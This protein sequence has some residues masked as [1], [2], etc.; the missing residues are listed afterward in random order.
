MVVSSRTPEGEPNRCPICGNKCCVEP[1]LTGDAPCPSC[2]HL[3]W[4]QQGAVCE[5]T[6]VRASVHQ[7]VSCHRE[8]L[9]EPDRAAWIGLD[10]IRTRENLAAFERSIADARDWDTVFARWF[11][12][13]RVWNKPDALRTGPRD[14]LAA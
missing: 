13:P 11:E 9:G 7:L 10:A 14:G 4:F 6:F 3:L 1:S 8:R 5:A 12:L 2:G